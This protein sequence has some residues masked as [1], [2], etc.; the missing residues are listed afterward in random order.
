MDQWTN[1]PMDQLTKGAIE[2]TPVTLG[3]EKT[4]LKGKNAQNLK[5][6]VPGYILARH[7]Y[8]SSCRS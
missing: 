6:W 3:K 8:K 5:K 1:G 2:E 7:H 4:L